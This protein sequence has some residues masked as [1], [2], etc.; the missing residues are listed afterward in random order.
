MDQQRSQMPISTFEDAEKPLAIAAGVLLWNQT[1]P[2]GQVPFVVKLRASADR[3]DNGSCGFWF[4]ASDLGEAL[5]GFVGPENRINLAIKPSDLLIQREETGIEL[6]EH[7]PEE[8]AE[9]RR[10]LI[11]QSLDLTSCAR[12]RLSKGNA[13]VQQQTAHL[14]H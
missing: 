4:N 6:G 14:R 12:H 8:F 3:R 13:A 11:Q 10:T 9:F 7:R 2:R 1:H 5:A